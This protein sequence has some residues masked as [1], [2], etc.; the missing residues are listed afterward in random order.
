MNTKKLILLSLLGSIAVALHAVEMMIPNPIPL[1]GAKLG[2][3]NVITL[4]VLV[5]YGLK[6]GLAVAFLRVVL[7]S[8]LSGTFLSVA[9]VM[10]FSGALTSALIMY[11]AFRY[12]RSLSIIGVSAAGA[13]THNLTQLTVAFFITET[14]YIFFYLPF[15]LL[16]GVAVGVL[17]GLIVKNL[18]KH[19]SLF[20]LVRQ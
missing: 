8:F 17:T 9:F 4:L 7:G 12:W 14:R 5:M 11:L 15:L 16:V 2:L 10:S 18:L 3:A 19:T 1:P 6:E 20:E 13:V